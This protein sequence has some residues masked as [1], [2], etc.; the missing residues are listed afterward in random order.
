MLPPDVEVDTLRENVESMDEFDLPFLTYKDNKFVSDVFSPSGVG[1]SLDGKSYPT[2]LEGVIIFYKRQRGRFRDRLAQEEGK[3]LKCHAPDGKTGYTY[4]G[5][6]AELDTYIPKEGISC[7]QCP[8]KNFVKGSNFRVCRNQFKL[9][10]LSKGTAV[11]HILY[12][13][14]ET[15]ELFV[16]NYLINTIVQKGLAYYKVVT[17][18]GF[19]NGKPYFK[20]MGILEGNCKEFRDIWLSCIK[21][22]V[23]DLN[24]ESFR[25]AFPYGLVDKC[26]CNMWQGCT[27]GMLHREYMAQHYVTGY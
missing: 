12:L 3:D 1:K 22:N 26:H 11:P 27:C 7:K 10:F 13:D 23:N 5:D 14:T 8:Y 17:K 9:Y 6:P 18:I 20:I 19:K 16:N 25:A 21:S 2:E 15:T 24:E 4:I